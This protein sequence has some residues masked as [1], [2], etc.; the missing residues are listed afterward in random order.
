M[1]ILITGTHFT[2][3]QA[4]IEQLKKDSK[5]EIVYLG[6][7]STREGDKSPSAESHTL[8]KMGVRFIPLVAGRLQRSLTFY[9]IPSLLKIPLGLL[10][11]LYLLVKEQPDVILSFGGYVAVPVV[12]AGWLFSIPIIIHEQTLI[13]GLANKISFLFAD[14]IAISFKAHDFYRSPKTVVT[15]NPLRQEVLLAKHN[16]HFSDHELEKIINI[17]RQNKLPVI[18]ISGGNQGSH[19]INQTISMVLDELTE[20]AC[21]IHQTGDSKFQDFE[22]LIVLKKNLQYP[23]R[24]Y[25][26]KWIEAHNIGKLFNKVDLAV[27]R[28]GINT[29]TE[30]AYFAKPTIVIPIPYLREQVINARFFER[31]GM[32]KT[33]GQKDLTSDRLLVFIKTI[34]KELP[35]YQIKAQKVRELVIKDAAS[36]LATETLILARKYD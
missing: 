18:L 4:V 11:A 28:A 14:K 29:L 23:D 6:R 1:K 36:R 20:L 5:I 17:A 16:S 7:K 24:Y 32:V 35:D 33:I 25:P 27:G 31:M 19:V 22:R 9:T 15:G 21:I 3:A 12:I 8:P 2:P 13:P 34:L 10:Q 26:T 30:L